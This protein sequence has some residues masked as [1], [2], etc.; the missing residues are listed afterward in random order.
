MLFIFYTSDF[1]KLVNDTAICTRSVSRVVYGRA[2]L[3]IM[4]AD[5][6]RYIIAI[7]HTAA[8]PVWRVLKT[9]RASQLN[10]SND[11]PDKTPEPKR[12]VSYI[13]MYIIFTLRA[14]Y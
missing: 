13:Y 14:E 6:R 11:G 7:I 8:D 12:T 10:L 2:L 3:L 4:Y 5:Y 9:N 1:Y